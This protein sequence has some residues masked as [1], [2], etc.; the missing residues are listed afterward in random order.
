MS[1][2]KQDI[3]TQN[4]GP[5][6]SKKVSF[7]NL[8]I[9]PDESQT[10]ENSIELCV[11]L[12]LVE[13]SSSKVLHNNMLKPSLEVAID[14]SVS[15]EN[16]Y[17]TNNSSLKE[18]MVESTVAIQEENSKAAKEETVVKENDSSSALSGVNSESREEMVNLV[19]AENEEDLVLASSVGGIKQA[20]PNG[21]GNRKSK[22]SEVDEEMLEEITRR[23][24][25]DVASHEAMS[26]LK[27]N[28]SK[29]VV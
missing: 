16:G 19:V 20:H 15:S 6:K 24:E 23:E 22:G 4:G 29:V 1:S 18:A 3:R 8:P 12:G 13:V 28:I 10:K 17:S 9:S 2:S 25:E 26:N 11:D 7:C 27:R 14:P 5:S 21:G